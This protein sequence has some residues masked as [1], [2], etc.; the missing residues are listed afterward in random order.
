MNNSKIFIPFNKLNATNDVEAIP[1]KL[2]HT[3]NES[4]QSFYNKTNE[5]VGMDGTAPLNIWFIAFCVITIILIVLLISYFIVTCTRRN[6][7]N[8]EYFDEYEEY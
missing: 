4:P 2:A 7:N 5:N 8:G 3:S 1:L 6:N